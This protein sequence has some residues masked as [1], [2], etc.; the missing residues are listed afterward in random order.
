MIPVSAH[1]ATT[2][3]WLLGN[4][5]T[6]HAHMVAIE[7]YYTYI[8]QHRAHNTHCIIHCHFN[9]TVLTGREII[10]WPH[11]GHFIVAF[12]E[13]WSLNTGQIY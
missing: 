6:Y 9:F 1:I 12:I 10:K 3:V 2:H 7:S 8:L 13:K 4:P 5:P 11:W